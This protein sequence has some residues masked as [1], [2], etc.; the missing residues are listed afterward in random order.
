MERTHDF[1]Y[2]SIC[3]YL[4]DPVRT[5]C[6]ARELPAVDETL[7]VENLGSVSSTPV[8]GYGAREEGVSKLLRHVPGII[9]VFERDDLYICRRCRYF[10]HEYRANIKGARAIV[11]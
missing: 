8:D 7:G 4:S 1:R 6:Q 10:N 11:Y 5:S 3:T 9:R 2:T